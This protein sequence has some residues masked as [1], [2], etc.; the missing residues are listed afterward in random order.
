MHITGGGFLTSS[1]CRSALSRLHCCALEFIPL[2]AFDAST[3]GA[4]SGTKFLLSLL[5]SVVVF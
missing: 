5:H 1:L 3:L 2:C 4:L